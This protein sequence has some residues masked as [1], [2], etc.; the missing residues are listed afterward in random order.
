MNNV[1]C[2]PLNNNSERLAFSICSIVNNLNEYKQMKE[3]FEEKGFSENCEYLIADNSKNNYFDAYQAISLFL[4]TAKAKYIIIVHQDVRCIDDRG[5][6]ENCLKHLNERDNKWAICGNAGAKGYHDAV[7]HITGPR[8][9]ETYADLPMK[10]NS[11]DENF[12]VINSTS[13][14]TISSD[15]SGY[16]LYGTDLSIIAHVLGHTCYVIPFMV[17]HLSEGN[18]GS[19]DKYLPDFLKKYG[20]KLNI[21]YVQTTCTQFYLSNSTMKNKWLNSPVFFFLIKQTKRWPYLF[22]QIGKNKKRTK[23]F[24]DEKTKSG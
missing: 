13:N 16:H 7:V 5:E 12:L 9:R 19:L 21:G 4:K 23:E 24:I 10:V 3:S 20:E 1:I 2:L 6:L 14:I 11:L 22:N 18:L 17:L 15:L 8:L